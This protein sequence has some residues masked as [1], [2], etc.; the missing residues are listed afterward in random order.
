VL[1]AEFRI[2]IDGAPVPA[3][4]MGAIGIDSTPEA[5]RETVVTEWGVQYGAPIGYAIAR[6]LGS[7]GPPTTR[8]GVSTSYP[9]VDV[10]GV[11]LY[12]G[13]PG[14]R[15][16]PADPGAISSEQFVRDIA[17]SAVLLMGTSNRFRS[18]TIQL[19]VDGSTVTDGE[20]RVNGEVSP[21][22]L[23]ELKKITW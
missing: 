13:P 7:A 21:V 5:A 1:A 10:D 16:T 4:V 12:H 14:T 20:C 18:A 22:L 15:G 23:A 2:A 19:A 8:G 3:F 6:W 9:R 17:A 11:A